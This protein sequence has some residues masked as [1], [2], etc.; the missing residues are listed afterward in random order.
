[1]II[2]DTR[3]LKCSKCGSKKYDTTFVDVCEYVKC[4][5]CGHKALVG[6]H[7]KPKPQEQLPKS[8]RMGKYHKF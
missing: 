5:K 2:N 7:S 4:K 6:I 1:M 8:Y 3:P